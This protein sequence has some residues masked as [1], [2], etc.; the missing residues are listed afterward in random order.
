MKPFSFVLLIFFLA[1]NGAA[2]SDDSVPQKTEPAKIQ[3]SASP[4]DRLPKMIDFGSKQC[5]ACKAMEAVLESCMKNH[6]ENFLTE[7]VDVWVA[8]NQMLAKSFK[9]QSIPTQVFLDPDGKEVFRHVGFISEEDILGKWQELGFDFTKASPTDID[10][11]NVD[12]AI[13]EANSDKD[14]SAEQH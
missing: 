12:P 8:E 6:A 5:K 1:F 2:C 3:P 13:P 14:D 7:F 9:I 4:A 11:T 10:R